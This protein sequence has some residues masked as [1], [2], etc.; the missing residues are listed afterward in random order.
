MY[1]DFY[2]VRINPTVFEDFGPEQVDTG[3]LDHRGDAIYKRNP[4]AKDPVG[5]IV[6]SSG[7]RKGI[8]SQ[9]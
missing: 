2:E 5:F 3:L 1:D 4:R 9:K 6:P 8:I 7:G